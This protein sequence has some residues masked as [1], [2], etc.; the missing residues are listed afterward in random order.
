M[1]NTLYG[2][3]VRKERGGRVVIVFSMGMLGMGE[4]EGECGMGEGL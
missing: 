4:G 1:G 2:G 3:G